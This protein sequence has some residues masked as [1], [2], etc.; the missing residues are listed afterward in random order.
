MFDESLFDKENLRII[1]TINAGMGTRHRDKPY[2]LNNTDD[3]KQALLLTTA[4]YRDYW[5]YW[6]T[7]ETIN[8][9][10]D[11]S[12]ENYD[13]AT[14][15]NIGNAPG[16]A[17]ELSLKAAAA[18]NKARLAFDELKERAKK[19]CALIIKAVLSTPPTAQKNVLG[20]SY[21]IK[22]EEI[23]D[24]IDELLDE[25]DESPYHYEMP[26]NRDALLKLMK[27]KWSVKVKKGDG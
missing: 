15:F 17:D 23:D 2:D 4:A 19:N 10:F 9:N 25:L 26:K 7:L 18:L 20:R 1:K 21:E 12:L 5:H 27:G 3:L 22:P 13:T 8:E 16:K 24:R 14:W 6:V 11:E